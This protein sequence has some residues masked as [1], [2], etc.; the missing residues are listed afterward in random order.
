M[1]RVTIVL[2]EDEQ[3]ALVELARAELRTPRD[4]ALVLLRH[5]LE[6]RGLLPKEGEAQFQQEAARV[7]HGRGKQ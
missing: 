6:R 5:E 3:K 2:R 7:C 1:S 4:Q